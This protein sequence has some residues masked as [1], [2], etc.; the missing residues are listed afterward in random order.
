M[1]ETRH[2]NYLKCF[3]DGVHAGMKSLENLFETEK[4]NLRNQI[5][6]LRGLRAKSLDEPHHVNTFEKIFSVGQ[7]L[8]NRCRIS[9][10]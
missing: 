7:V 3:G 10:K 5:T 9:I 8:E 6:S 1:Y 4:G 2:A